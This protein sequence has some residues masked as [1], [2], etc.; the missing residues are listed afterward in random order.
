MWICNMLFRILFVKSKHL[1]I[2][3][4]PIRSGSWYYFLLEKKK[5]H[6]KMVMG[7]IHC[8]WSETKILHRCVTWF[9]L[10]SL[11]SPRDSTAGRNAACHEARSA[12]PLPSTNPWV[13]HCT[14]PNLFCHYSLLHLSQLTGSAQP[15]P[16]QGHVRKSLSKNARTDQFCP[17]V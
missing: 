8:L 4:N 13:L 17:S 15:K 5:T 9:Q 1:N 16:S 14:N 3:N 7:L 11:S 10:C 12:A 6:Q 2:S